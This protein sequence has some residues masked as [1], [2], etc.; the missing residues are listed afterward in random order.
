MPALVDRMAYVGDQPWWVGLEKGEAV[1]LGGGA[2][3]A[4]VMA[5]RSGLA[6]WRVDTTPLYTRHDFRYVTVQHRFSVTRSDNG[7]SLG[8]VSN[9]YEP[10][11]NTE[12]FSFFDEVVSEGQAIYHT[13]GS[14]EGGRKVWILAKLPDS[15]KIAGVDLIENFLLLMNAHDGTLAFRFI[16]TPIR[17]VCNNTLNMALYGAGKE[18]GY[19]LSHFQ[20]LRGRLNADD[21]RQA[22]GLAGEWFAA[23]TGSAQVLAQTPI[24]A[25]Q[26][27]GLLQRLFPIPEKLLLP[28]GTAAPMLLLPEPRAETLMPEFRSVFLK[29]DVVRGL[30]NK[31]KGNTGE[32][33]WDAFNGVA[34]FT[35]Y[36][37]GRNSH[38]AAN[39]LYGDGQQLKQEA[40]NLLVEDKLFGVD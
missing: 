7:E 29:R 1:N 26:K 30:I 6:A 36:C 14:L 38:R 10:L 32:T 8:I 4:E 18:S 15:V 40:W 16:Q 19:R 21:A 25:E 24:S 22:V 20:T 39:L 34:E 17:V 12:C 31:G 11:Q 37:M 27:E 28:A 13:A 33:R 23:F 2:V 35:D 3:T 9:R 5:E